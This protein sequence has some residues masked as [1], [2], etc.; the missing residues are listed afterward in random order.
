[1]FKFNRHSFEMKYLSAI[2]LPAA[3]SA[4]FGGSSCPEYDVTI[5][6]NMFN[7][8]LSP[9]VLVAHNPDTNLYD[10]RA[11]ASNELK[12]IALN[13]N[14][15]PMNAFLDGAAAPKICGHVD[16]DPISVFSQPGGPSATVKL[17]TSGGGNDCS[18]GNMV[19]TYLSML[20]STNDGVAT[21]RSYAPDNREADFTIDHVGVIDAGVEANDDTLCDNF[22][23][24][25][26]NPDGTAQCPPGLPNNNADNDPSKVVLPHPGTSMAVMG[27]EMN[28]A[29][30]LEFK[31]VANNNNNNWWWLLFFGDHGGH[32]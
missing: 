9:G 16:V 27:W 12:E 15:A 18:C 17:T 11:E 10:Y 30:E 31:V 32:H 7:Q 25:L 13:G 28:H 1:M 24:G 6:N 20:T 14:I 22:P 23:G 4:F 3:A 19:F 29:A 2:M 8:I 21:V 26:F 5:H